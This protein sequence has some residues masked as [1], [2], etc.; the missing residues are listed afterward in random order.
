MGEVLASVYVGVKMMCN[1]LTDEE[2]NA[3]CMVALMGNDPR[4]I[5]GYEKVKS[6]FTLNEGTK[7]HATAL[8]AF[9]LVRNER[10]PL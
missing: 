9:V 7:M 1:Q 8:D 2:L 4:H 3:L 6:L 10:I 5:I